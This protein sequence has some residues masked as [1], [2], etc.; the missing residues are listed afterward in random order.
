MPRCL[1]SSCG[2]DRSV[3]D[4]LELHRPDSPGLFITGTDTGVGKTVATCLIAD[5]MRRRGPGRG[6]GGS[7]LGALKPIATGCRRER[8]GLVS[9]DAEQ[10]AHASAFD[11]EIGDLTLVNPVR[12]RPAVAPAVALEQTDRD[13]IDWPAI[14]RSLRRMDAGCDSILIEGI[15]GVMVPL[16]RLGSGGRARTV[17]VLDLM[18]AIGYPVAVVCRADLGTLNHTALTCE[19]IRRVGLPLAGLIINGYDPD[20]PDE[21]VQSNRRWLAIQNDVRV[22]A[23]L[24]GARRGEQIGPRRGEQAW[25]VRRIPADLRDA[26]DAADFASLCRSASG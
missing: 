9:P 25:D 13:R 23:I 14:D 16:E 8:E 4:A 12:F 20:S 17:T 1:F 6:S 11:P 22:L 10:I 3:N 2:Y 26:I 18:A 5:Q 21:S 19:A 15:G 7:R 24:P